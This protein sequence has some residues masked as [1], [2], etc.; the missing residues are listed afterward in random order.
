M[1]VHN[2]QDALA[3]LQRMLAELPNPEHRR[4]LPER[5]YQLVAAAYLRHVTWGTAMRSTPSLFIAQETGA[6]LPTVQGWVHR[7]R[8]RGYLPPA[9]RGQA[10]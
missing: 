4:D 8:R 10:G 9:R 5:F 7:A 2:E 1:K 3:Q 6:P